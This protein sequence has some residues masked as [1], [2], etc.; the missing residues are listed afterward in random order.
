MSI[1]EPTDEL[2]AEPVNVEQLLLEVDIITA[3]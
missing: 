3:M 2:Y 1:I